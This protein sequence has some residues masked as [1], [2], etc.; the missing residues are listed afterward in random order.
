MSC[1][2]VLRFQ[3]VPDEST[4][5][6]AD[7]SFFDVTLGAKVAEHQDDFESDLGWQPDLINSTASTGQWVL[8]D[9]EATTYQPGQDVTVGGTDCW[10]TASNSSDGTDDVDDGIVILLSPVF[11]LSNLADADVSYYRWYANSQPG[12]D[13]GDFF[14]VDVSDD[15]GMSWANLE[16]LDSGV[17]APSWT[18]QSFSLDDHISLTNQVMFRVQVQDAAPTG[19]V[20]EGAIDGFRIDRIEC[21]DTPACFTEPTFSGLETAASGAS[22]GEVDLSW[23]GATSNC[24]NAVITYNVYRSTDAGFT[25]GPGTLVASGLTG[26]SAVDSLLELGQSYHYVVRAFDSRSGEES[27]TV[28]RTAVAPTSPDVQAPQFGGIETASTGADCGATVLSWSP[29]LEACNSPVTYEVYRSTD[30]GFS[31]GPATLVGSTLSTSLVDA[32]LTP[33]Q[34]YTYVVRA[35]D[36][37]GNVDVNLTKLTVGSA[38]LDLTLFETAFEPDDAGWA[39]VAPNDAATGNWQWGDPLTTSYQSGDDATPGGR[40]RVDHR[41][42]HRAEQQRRGR[43]DHDAS[44]L[45][46]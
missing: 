14:G 23:Q 28:I 38:Q 30:P 44:V 43:R 4:G 3:F 32:A 21:D 12:A 46:L 19:A 25:P 17:T 11:D 45:A 2:D 9:P 40:E 6:A 39:V 35:K 33:G 36:N 13:P 26:T 1:G 24:I 7:T 34:G 8:G 37:V 18:Q 22:C 42:L 41:T 15:G 27:N 20:V 16:T 31:P 10:F 29:A 5:C